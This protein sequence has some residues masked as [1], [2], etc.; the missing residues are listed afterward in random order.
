M[1]AKQ[2]PTRRG[3]SKAPATGN[4]VEALTAPSSDLTPAEQQPQEPTARAEG[5]SDAG[6]AS[7]RRRPGR[8]RRKAPAEPFSTRLPVDLR[9]E[10]ELFRQERGMTLTAV[11]EDALVEYMKGRGHDFA[12]YAAE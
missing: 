4:P 2:Q 5:K 1:N 7:T 6:E 8:P 9:D 3:L 12:Y 11:V 10:L